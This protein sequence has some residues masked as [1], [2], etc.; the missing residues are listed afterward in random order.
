MEGICHLSDLCSADD[1]AGA[2]GPSTFA[3]QA[4]IHSQWAKLFPQLVG[5]ANL[6]KVSLLTF[7]LHSTAALQGGTTTNLLLL[8]GFG[9]LNGTAPR[10]FP[11][12]WERQDFHS[13]FWGAEEEQRGGRQTHFDG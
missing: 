3:R 1:L 10:P 4:E 9:S 6:G 2:S 7:G 5:I 13:C 8:A 12:S 11:K